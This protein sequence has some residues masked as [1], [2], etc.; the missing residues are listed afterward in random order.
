[1]NC[2]TR[3]TLKLKIMIGVILSLTSLLSGCLGP[4]YEPSPEQQ[5]LSLAEDKPYP[6]MDSFIFED[7]AFGF[8]LKLSHSPSSTKDIPS[9]IDIDKTIRENMS[10]SN[11]RADGKIQTILECFQGGDISE[12]SVIGVPNKSL[13]IKGATAQSENPLQGKDVAYYMEA[14]TDLEM[15]SFKKET[16]Y[17]KGS[18]Q[19]NNFKTEDFVAYLTDTYGVPHYTFTKS[20]RD[21]VH[22]DLWWGADENNLITSTGYDFS[23]ASHWKGFRGKTFFVSIHNYSTGDILIGQTM[24]DNFRAFRNGLAEMIGQ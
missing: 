2:R 17:S 13:S 1:M 18:L 11:L 9:V 16:K 5:L 6:V 14:N 10:P 4:T 20:N 3:K 7:M 8:T 15:I 19:K 22:R 24:K 12:I 21:G 23:N